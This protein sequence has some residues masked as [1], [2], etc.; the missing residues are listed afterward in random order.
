M[1]IKEFWN[2]GKSESVNNPWKIL[3]NDQLSYWVRE[4]RHTTTQKNRGLK[5]FKKWHNHQVQLSKK[6]T[7]L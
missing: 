2:S 1:E 4:G 5:I 3:T 7:S 6:D